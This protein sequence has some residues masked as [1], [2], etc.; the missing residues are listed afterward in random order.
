MH[1]AGVQIARRRAHRLRE[2]ILAKMGAGLE[3]RR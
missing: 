1:D 3:R 2:A